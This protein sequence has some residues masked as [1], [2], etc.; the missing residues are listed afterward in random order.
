MIIL[1][2]ASKIVFILLAVSLCIFTYMGLIDPKDFVSTVGMV[3]VYYFG[4]NQNPP[5]DSTKE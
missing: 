2:S 3:M 5:N 1:S 4:K